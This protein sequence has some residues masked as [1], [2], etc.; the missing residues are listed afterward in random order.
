MQISGKMSF[1]GVEIANVKVPRW[2][3]VWHVPRRTGK[4]VWLE[5]R[6]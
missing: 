4:P 5:L 6:E 3:S 1:Q 2:E